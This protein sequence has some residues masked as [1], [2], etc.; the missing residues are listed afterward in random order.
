MGGNLY[1]ACTS[2]DSVYKVPALF[3]CMVVRSNNFEIEHEKK[4][5]TKNILR[6]IF[7]ITTSGSFETEN[8]TRNTIRS[9]HLKLYSLW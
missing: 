4:L 6:F 7:M 3:I 2:G 1:V 8:L 9:E 5:K